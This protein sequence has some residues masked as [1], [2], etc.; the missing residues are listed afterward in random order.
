MVCIYNESI[1]AARYV[2]IELVD[3]SC[4][5]LYSHMIYMGCK[6]REPMYMGCEDREPMYMG[7]EDREP[8]YMGCED[9]EPMYMGCEDRE[10]MYKGCEDREPMY[11]GCGRDWVGIGHWSALAMEVNGEK[12]GVWMGMYVGN[13]QP[14]F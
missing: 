9:R 4:T 3:D 11:M 14:L 6:D 10:P 5:I 7:C 13:I 2:G 8:M 1:S 12:G